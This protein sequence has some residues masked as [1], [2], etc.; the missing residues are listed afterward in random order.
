MKYLAP[1]LLL[2][3]CDGLPKDFAGTLPRVQQERVFRVGLIAEG[4]RSRCPDIAPAFLARVTAATGASPRVTQGAAEPL[5]DA[6]KQGELDLVLGELDPSSPWQT[7]VAIL[8][9]IV[10]ACPGDVEYSAVAR[11]GENRWIMLL[12][13]AGRAMRR[14]GG[15]A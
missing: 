13:D 1:L 12:E 14:H 2:A 9:P 4:G 8:E 10:S 15:A 11:N 6:L 5:L 3:A 7:E